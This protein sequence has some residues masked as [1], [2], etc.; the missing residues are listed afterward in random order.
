MLGAV[1]LTALQILRRSSVLDRIWAEDG[2]IFGREAFDHTLVDGIGRGYSGYLVVVPRMLAAPIVSLIAPDKWGAWFA[3]TSAL[4]ATFCGLAVFRVSAGVITSPWARAALALALTLGPKMRGEW[5][6]I[7]NV[8]WP[9]LM[10]LT[11]M[12]I[13]VR[14]DTFSLLLRVGITVAAVTSSGLGL[15]F[16][17]VVLIVLWARRAPK[18]MRSPTSGTSPETTEHRT[19]QQ[20]EQ[21]TE[22]STSEHQ[23]QVRGAEH[24]AD[25]I[26]AVAFFAALIAQLI[27]IATAPKGPPAE[28]TSALDVIRLIAVRVFGAS[29]VGDRAVDDVWLSLHDVLSVTSVVIVVLIFAFLA[30][31]SAPHVRVLGLG[32]ALIG[33]TVGVVPLAIRGTARFAIRTDRFLFDADRY[34]LVPSFLLLSALLILADGSKW[35]AR[36]VP[37]VVAHVVVVLVATGYA[38]SNPGAGDP[39]WKTNLRTATQ[40]CRAANPP[41]RLDIPIAPAGVFRLNV[42]CARLRS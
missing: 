6:A 29:I 30:F 2:A 34:F 22:P 4:V 20:T 31:S 13:S 35:R 1:V 23:R 8:A 24:R 25:R 26:V 9:L 14:T 15:L 7:A 18:T 12:L 41:D 32:T 27:G 17:P 39:S 5:P 28:A 21:Q 40:Q 11:W 19:E 38:L 10:A 16:T 36:V 42:P 3:L 33:L 37:V